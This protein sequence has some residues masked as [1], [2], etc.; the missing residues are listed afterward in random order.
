MN[1]KTIWYGR[2][3]GIV[4]IALGVLALV[5]QFW[6]LKIGAFLWPFFIIVPGVLC[7]LFAMSTEGDLG[8]GFSM[9]SGLI[10]SVGVLL[11][12]Q[13][14]TGHWTSW[15]Y[16]WALVAPTGVGLGRMLYGKLKQ[17][18]TLVREGWSLVRLGLVMAVIGLIFFELVLNIS[19]FGLGFIGWPILFIGLGLIFLLRGLLH[20]RP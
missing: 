6:H 16:A 9:L 8:E 18:G 17:R 10:V 19:G 13:S 11:L 7:F 1:E 5:G 15:S 12:Y 20:R 14:L 4:L 2:V 3:F